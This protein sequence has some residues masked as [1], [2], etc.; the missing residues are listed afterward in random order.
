M[1]R[2]AYL[3]VLVLSLST[4]SQAQTDRPLPPGQRLQALKIAY[5]TKQLNLTSEEAEKFWPVYNNYTNELR[6]VRQDKSQDVLVQEENALNLRKKYQ[7]EFKRIL[8]TDERANKV[9]TVDRDFNNMIRKELQ[10]RM[11]KRKKDHPTPPVQ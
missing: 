6:K 7:G 4:M 1:K 11:E 3:L 8:N 9:L 10:Q 5:V 2:F